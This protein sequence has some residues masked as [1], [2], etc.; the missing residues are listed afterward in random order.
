MTSGTF[1]QYI[2]KLG[3]P[4][5][6]IIKRWS[7]QILKRLSYLHSHRSLIVHRDIKCNSIFVNGARGEVKIGNPDISSVNKEKGRLTE[8]V[9]KILCNNLQ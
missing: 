3:L 9:M 7:R 8:I 1:R 2:Q 6:K 5:V 4:N